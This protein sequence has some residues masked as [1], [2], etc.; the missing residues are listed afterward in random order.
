MIVFD[1]ERLVRRHPTEMRRFRSWVL[2]AQPGDL[3][4]IVIEHESNGSCC[5]AEAWNSTA[6][7]IITALEPAT[8][9]VLINLNDPTG[10]TP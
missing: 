3:E 1:H 10:A 8:P 4:R 5:R 7:S 6:A 2:S 9:Q